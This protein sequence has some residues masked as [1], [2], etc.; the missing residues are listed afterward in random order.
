MGLTPAGGASFHDPQL[1][2]V[3][4]RILSTARRITARVSGGIVRMTVPP[5]LTAGELDKAVDSMRP[6]LLDALRR[7]AVPY[8]DGYAFDTCDWGFTLIRDSLTPPLSVAVTTAH[9]GDRTVAEIHYGTA[10]DFSVPAHARFMSDHICVLARHIAR[11][12]IIPA[13][14]G[15]AAS[16]GCRPRVIKVSRGLRVLGHCSASGEIALSEKTAFLP[17]DLRRYIVTHELAHLTHMDHSAAF[18]ALWESYLGEPHRAMRA[19]LR[20]FEWPVVR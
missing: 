9:D 20:G 18:T 17:A 16:L 10:L 3:H 1:G 2:Q 8:R 6:A 15:I 5:G 19:R 7:M 11:T 13:A 14:C 12:R 4:V